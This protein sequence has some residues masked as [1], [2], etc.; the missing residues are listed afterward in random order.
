MEECSGASNLA[1]VW[2]L[3]PSWCPVPV[4]HADSLQTNSRG[5]VNGEDVRKLSWKYG[6]VCALRSLE[7]AID[8]A[9]SHREHPSRAFQFAHAQGDRKQFSLK[10]MSLVSRVLINEKPVHLSCKLIKSD[11]IS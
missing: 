4:R 2:W 6:H 8:D 5:N 10:S 7:L 1:A 9:V 3:L 11:F